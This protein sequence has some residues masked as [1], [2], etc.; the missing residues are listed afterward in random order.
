MLAK[1][2]RFF[3]ASTKRWAALRRTASAMGFHINHGPMRQRS[4]GEEK[5]RLLNFKNVQ[6]T[7]YVVWKR[8]A[9][10]VWLNN[11]AALQIY[12][13]TTEFPAGQKKKAHALLKR[14]EQ[15]AIVGGMVVYERWAAV[16]TTLSLATQAK[17]AV[18]PILYHT[19]EG[20]RRRLESISGALEDF[21]L[22][23]D[24]EARTYKNVTVRGSRA[25]LE[26]L[27]RWSNVLKDRTIQKLLTRFPLQEG[28]LFW[29]ASLFDRRTWPLADMQFN[30]DD[31]ENKLLAVKKNFPA[32]S[33]LHMTTTGFVSLVRAL[34]VQVP[35]ERSHSGRVVGRD[36]VAAWVYAA[37]H[38]H[39][40][41][42][43]PVIDCAIALCTVPLSQT[44]CEQLNSV[45]KLVCSSRR[46]LLSGEHVTD[47]VV[48]RTTQMPDAELV[49]DAVVRWAAVCERR[50]AQHMFRP[51]RAD[52]AD[53]SSEGFELSVSSRT[54]N[55]SDSSTCHDSTNSCSENELDTSSDGSSSNATVSV[56]TRTTPVVMK[57]VDVIPIM[58]EPQAHVCP[59]FQTMLDSKPVLRRFAAALKKEGFD[60]KETITYLTV[61]DMARLEIPPAVRRLLEDEKR[62]LGHSTNAN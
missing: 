46:S 44:S 61:E 54:T 26:M 12:L 7:R 20:A 49:H 19:V 16:L 29:G 11:L 28:G 23:C 10:H 47:E 14:A 42:W 33:N 48:V 60:T 18:L 30:P 6:K 15:V 21:V 5:K 8:W 34:T 51:S 43:R 24:L 4:R 9:A 27:A 3:S 59:W 32:A 41:E 2:A 50:T 40:K 57:A 1:T 58:D 35:P 52:F 62:Q 22:H 56:Q 13:R 45:V 39:T 36:A 37:N 53:S 31:V 17:W 55:S 25:D 38:L